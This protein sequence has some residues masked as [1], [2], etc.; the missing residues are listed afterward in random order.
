MSNIF[1]IVYFKS[2]NFV[3]CQVPSSISKFKCFYFTSYF[4]QTISIYMQTQHTEAKAYVK[5]ETPIT[6]LSNTVHTFV[7]ATTAISLLLIYSYFN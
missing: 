2:M 4:I 5:P 6:E 3:S 1:L 7:T